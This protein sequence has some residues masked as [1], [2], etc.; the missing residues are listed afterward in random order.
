LIFFLSFVFVFVSNADPLLPLDLTVCSKQWTSANCPLLLDGAL[1]ACVVATG[2]PNA[3]N[4][5]TCTDAFADTI[6]ANPTCLRL[7]SI[8][9]EFG[10]DPFGDHCRNALISACA[11]AYV[12]YCEMGVDGLNL[13]S[14]VN[15]T[16][17][18]RECVSGAVCAMSVI[19]TRDSAPPTVAN[20][21][22]RA[23]GGA[24]TPCSR[25][26]NG[27]PLQNKEPSYCLPD[28]RCPASDGTNA[29]CEPTG[30][31]GAPGQACTSDQ[32][33][34]GFLQSGR[35]EFRC[36]ANQPNVCGYI[37]AGADCT[38]VAAFQGYGCD[39]NTHYCNGTTC[40]PLN[41]WGSACPTNLNRRAVCEAPSQCVNATATCST[42]GV[43]GGLCQGEAQNGDWCQDSYCDYSTQPRR[44]VGVPGE[45]DPCNMWNA[46]CSIGLVCGA[47]ATT[48]MPTTCVRPFSKAD[49]ERCATAMECQP[50]SA[51]LQTGV[52]FYGE[53]GPVSGGESD[54][55]APG[56][57]GTFPNA[58]CSAQLT[59][60]T[61]CGMAAGCNFAN[62]TGGNSKAG[63]EILLY[64][65]QGN[66]GSIASSFWFPSDSCWTAACA[67]E[68]SCLARCY[69]PSIIKKYDACNDGRNAFPA[70]TLTFT[71]G[72]AGALTTGDPTTGSSTTG[73]VTTTGTTTGVATTTGTTTGTT[74]A[75]VVPATTGT[76]T[77]L[78]NCLV[79]SFAV[80]FVLA[81]LL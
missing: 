77:S 78:A 76:E 47:N 22:C 24:G 8:C 58:D 11:G 20:S 80:I 4:T 7:G 64:I 38:S 51:C 56:Y 12:Q 62:A 41:T 50:G 17:I 60:A 30:S 16:L 35:S 67:D 23:R 10:N 2:G 39:Q 9:R 49:G 48:N 1:Q 5:K 70:C 68:L 55:T 46:D 75:A 44:C 69:D 79:P 33:C 81:A 52:N 45:G 26:A 25:P 71:T 61:Q 59:A 34:Q 36:G 32:E 54:C 37:A 27:S 63:R 21:K 42:P 43:L 40:V 6:R 72:T 19:E 14:S 28:H 73:V 18:Y 13:E 29:T 31:G 53:C 15:K 66:S 65:A 74:T 3:T 57:N